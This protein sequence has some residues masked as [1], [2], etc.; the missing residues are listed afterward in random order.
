LKT[1]SSGSSGI[2]LFFNLEILSKKQSTMADIVNCKYL[3]HLF[4][5][6]TSSQ[7]YQPATMPLLTHALSSSGESSLR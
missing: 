6:L 4:S 2:F 3:Y 7:L 5:I 1:A